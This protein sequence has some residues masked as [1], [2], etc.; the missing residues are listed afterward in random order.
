MILLLSSTG[1]FNLK[2][3][4]MKG[5]NILRLKLVFRVSLA[6]KNFFKCKKVVTARKRLHFLK[7]KLVR[8]LECHFYASRLFNRPRRGSRDP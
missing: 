4:K 7:L 2:Y 1:K 3:C 6:Q 8:G 5:L